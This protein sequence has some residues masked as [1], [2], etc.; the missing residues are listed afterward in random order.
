[1]RNS[2]RVFCINCASVPSDKVV[3]FS[4]KRYGVVFCFD[5]QKK[6]ID[7]K[8]AID[9]NFMKDLKPYERLNKLV[10]LNKQ[11]YISLRVKDELDKVYLNE[12][13]VS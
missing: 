3:D 9:K 4:M 5:C 7:I 13:K 1:M 12:I 10:D 8:G 11:G 6:L 2:K